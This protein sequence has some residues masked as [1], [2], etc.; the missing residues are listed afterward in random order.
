MVVMALEN[1]YTDFNSIYNDFE[2]D[3]LFSDIDVRSL[4]RKYSLSQKDFTKMCWIVKNNHGLERRPT[5]C[6]HY[7]TRPNGDIVIERRIKGELYY[8]GFLKSHQKNKLDE[9]LR[10][11]DEIGWN[12]PNECRN[13]INRLKN[14]ENFLIHVKDY[15]RLFPLILVDTMEGKSGS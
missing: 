2:H 12:N 15:M 14:D 3:Y 5:T 6:K 13:A 4:R 1:V 8:Y 9:A 11:C 10:L 7:Y